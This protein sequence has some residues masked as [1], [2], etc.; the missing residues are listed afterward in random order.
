MR[1]ETVARWI[2]HG[3][4][5]VGSNADAC[6]ETYGQQLLAVVGDERLYSP[7]MESVRHR[8]CHLAL[9]FGSLCSQ[10]L[11]NSRCRRCGPRP[12]YRWGC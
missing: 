1:V 11:S 2:D 3:A 12:Q 7:R 8:D 6:L 4:E 9:I 5:I 10:N